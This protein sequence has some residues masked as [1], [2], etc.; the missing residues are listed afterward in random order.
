MRICF[1][2][3]LIILLFFTFVYYFLFEWLIFK[4]SIYWINW[5][6]RNCHWMVVVIASVILLLKCLFENRNIK[7]LESEMGSFLDLIV[8]LFDAVILVLP[9]FFF[10]GYGTT[11]KILSEYGSAMESTEKYIMS[12]KEIGELDSDFK[13]PVILPKGKQVPVPQ[14][15]TNPL[16]R[17]VIDSNYG[18]PIVLP[19][20]ISRIRT[21]STTIYRYSIRKAR[22]A[23]MPDSASILLVRT[24]GDPNLDEIL[25]SAIKSWQYYPDIEVEQIQ[26]MV[27]W[28]MR[29]INVEISG[30][31][32]PNRS[33]KEK[34]PNQFIRYSN[35]FQIE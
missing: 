17:P 35:D 1:I 4:I 28:D 11:S 9:A 15:E 20:D 16:A 18:T 34:M 31:T 12:I 23:S 6:L 5:F 8:L 21:S 24:S 13:I 22:N 25:E 30:M 2:Y 32:A 14:P 26:I 33:E 3:L 29:T 7:K 10:I 19:T 27:R